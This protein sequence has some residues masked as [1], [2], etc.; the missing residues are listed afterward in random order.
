V[1]VEGSSTGN[2]KRGRPPLSDS[3]DIYLQDMPQRRVVITKNL[4]TKEDYKEY[5]ILLSRFLKHSCKPLDESDS[6][7]GSFVSSLMIF[8]Q[9]KSLDDDNGDDDDFSLLI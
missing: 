6:L 2:R 9:Y 8:V 3:N 4:F 7:Q 5:G 1:T